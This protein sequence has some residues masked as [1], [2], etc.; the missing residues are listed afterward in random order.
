MLNAVAGVVASVVGAL[1]TIGVF[2]LSNEAGQ[3]MNDQ[4]SHP[5]AMEFHRARLGAMRAAIDDLI[6]R[7]PPSLL[8][9]SPT[10]LTIR[11]RI[12][13]GLKSAPI[14][15]IIN[16]PARYDDIDQLLAPAGAGAA[17]GRADA[18]QA[19]IELYQV[20]ETYFV[21][22]GNQR[23]CE[24]RARGQLFLLARV[25][26]YQI[27]GALEDPADIYAHLLL[28]ERQ[29]FLCFTGLNQISP[30][31]HIECTALG[32]Y[33]ELIRQI[34]AYGAEL[35]VRL[36]GTIERELA[37]ASWYDS[38]YAPITAALRRQRLL[39]ELPGRREADLYLW[40]TLRGRRL[41]GESLVPDGRRD[42]RLDALM[43]FI[44]NLR[45]V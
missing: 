21:K 13:R 23:V 4:V 43:P 34:E 8:T 29:R 10:Q 26:E 9:N 19:L 17:A 32:S 7:R 38:L 16:R 24:A 5:L 35:A 18:E 30:A 22:D 15:Q 25:T 31:Q 40:A 3:A 6:R 39:E 2:L 37:V 42:I 28:D 1:L 11:A 14:Y 27:Q 12:D 45:S 36:G 41:L 20:A 44:V 33:A